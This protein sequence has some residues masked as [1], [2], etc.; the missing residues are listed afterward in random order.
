MQD[1]ALDTL[2]QLLTAPTVDDAVRLRTAATVLTHLL[3]L[4][5]LRDVEERLAALEQA[6]AQE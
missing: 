3:K 6:Y 1:R 5:E 2:D 4:R